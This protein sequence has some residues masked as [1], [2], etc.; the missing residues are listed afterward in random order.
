L[1]PFRLEACVRQLQPYLVVQG[2][3]ISGGYF[4]ALPFLEKRSFL[5]GEGVGYLPQPDFDPAF[6]YYGAPPSSSRVE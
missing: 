3:I 2:I 1:T 5:L 4:D 6:D